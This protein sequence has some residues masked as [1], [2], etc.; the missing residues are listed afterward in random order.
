MPQ[1]ARAGATAPATAPATDD[2]LLAAA[3]EV[4]LPSG[5]RVWWLAPDD[6]EMLAFT[7]ELPDPITAAIYLLLEDE[8]AIVKDGD[9]GSYQRKRNQDNAKHVI[10]K[11][12]LIKPRY[13]PDLIVGD[14]MN[15][16]GRR[17][18]GRGDRDYIYN[19]LFRVGAAAPSY[20]LPNAD[21][22]GGLAHA[23]S[24]RGD[25]PHGAGGADQ[26]G[27]QSDRPSTGLLSESSGA[28]G[29]HT[30]PEAESAR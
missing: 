27:D 20:A 22:P 12:G 1:L 15:V 10:A 24:D 6:M 8:G 5:R 9:P 14:G 7:G 28:L 17:Q 2:E 26:A 13:D 23:A 25:L 4:R 3:E 30:L 19:W 18:L 16:I 11:A 29:G 21:Q